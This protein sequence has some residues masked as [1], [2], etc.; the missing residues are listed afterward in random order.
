VA[1][2]KEIKRLGKGWWLVVG[3]WWLVDIGNFDHYAR[4]IKQ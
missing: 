3:G 1:E 4:F 2:G